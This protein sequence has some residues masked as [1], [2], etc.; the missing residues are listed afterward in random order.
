[1]AWYDG[2]TDAISHPIDS[3]GKLGS[4][5]WGAAKGGYESLFGSPGTKAGLDK[6]SND[7]AALG[8]AGRDYQEKGLN[9]S[10]GYFG[11]SQDL[12]NQQKTALSGPSL[13]QQRYADLQGGNDPY[14]NYM[15]QRGNKQL[16]NTFSA[17]GGFNSGARLQ[18]G[19]DFQANLAAQQ[20]QQMSGL[21]GQAD[22]EQRG[23]LADIFGRQFGI[24]QG[25]AGATEKAYGAG[26]GFF[27]RGQ[28]ASIEAALQKAGIDDKT[29][30]ALFK[31]LSDNARAGVSMANPGKGA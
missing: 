22:Q 3:A 25:E 18:A 27:E 30:Q 11:Q 10:L 13:S 20:S 2:F 5:A 29:R 16:D 7:A 4:G 23:R 12:L 17:Q 26:G 6:A 21:A 15:L 9:Q 24:S 1:M 8:T 19:S 14:F 28:M 31:F